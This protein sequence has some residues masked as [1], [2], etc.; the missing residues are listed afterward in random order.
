[1]TN[2]DEFESSFPVSLTQSVIWG[3][4]DAFQHINN[5]VYFRYFENVRIE[6]F[7]RIGINA[8]MDQK[9]IGPILG[10][11]ECKYLAPITFPDDIVIATN[12]VELREKRFTMV[13][14]IFSSNLSKVVAKGKGEIIYFDYNKNETCFVPDEIIKKITQL[15]F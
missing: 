2:I 15:S 1:M 12:V 14:E 13:Y 10:S 5:T 4:M 11:T 6:Y 8:L 9:K 3:D 7:E